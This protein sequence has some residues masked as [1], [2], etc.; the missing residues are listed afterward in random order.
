MPCASPTLFDLL[1]IVS[2][3]GTRVFAFVCVVMVDIPFHETQTGRAFG[4]RG[5]KIEKRRVVGLVKAIVVVL[6]AL[7]AL[8]EQ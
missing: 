7:L 3:R 2:E 6:A 5:W 8:N 1:R 4:R